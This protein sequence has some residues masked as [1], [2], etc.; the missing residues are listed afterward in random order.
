VILVDQAAENVAP[1]D[2]GHEDLDLPVASVT[3]GSDVKS[4]RNTM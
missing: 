4:A 2:L 1:L 3:F